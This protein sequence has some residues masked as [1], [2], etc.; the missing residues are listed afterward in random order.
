MDRTIR[1]RITSVSGT[2][3]AKK[4]HD[5]AMERWEKNILRAIY[6]VIKERRDGVEE[7]MLR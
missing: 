6:G 3:V 7:L 5:V 2:W 1:P 4:A